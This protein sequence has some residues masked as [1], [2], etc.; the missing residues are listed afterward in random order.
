[1]F[2]KFSQNLQENT[3]ARVSFLVKFI[4]KLYQKETLTQVL[5]CEI[6]EISKNTFSTEHLSV[7]TSAYTPKFVF[8]MHVEIWHAYQYGMG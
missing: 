6:W 5:F 1:M 2:L 4:K 8:V 7:T 3:C